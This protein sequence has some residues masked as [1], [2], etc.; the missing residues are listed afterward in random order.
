MWYNFFGCLHF[1]VSNI[2]EIN[3]LNWWPISVN[4]KLIVLGWIRRQ[5][6]AIVKKK[7][8]TYE[9][10]CKLQREFAINEVSKR[11]VQLLAS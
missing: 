2:H 6:N 4:L 5:M 7:R 8:N 10:A 1:G 9:Q 11:V 3:T